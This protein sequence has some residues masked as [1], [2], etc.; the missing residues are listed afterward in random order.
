MTKKGS[1]WQNDFCIPSET[2]AGHQV[3]DVILRK[4]GELQWCPKDIFAIHLALEEALVNAIRHGNRSRQEKLVL[5]HTEITPE[6]FLTRITDE[7]PGFDPEALPDPTADEFL[8]CPSGRGVKLMQNFM[9]S[10]TFNAAGN[11]VTLEKIN[12]GSAA[13]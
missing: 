6:R 8:E 4:L 12:T 2:D 3:L 9:T 11:E 10:V 1:R 7:G 13:H 5:I